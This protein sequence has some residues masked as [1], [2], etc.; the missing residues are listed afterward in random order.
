L[1]IEAGDEGAVL[2]PSPPEDVDAAHPYLTV[3][4]PLST[5]S[6]RWGG[7]D[8]AAA[9]TDEAVVFFFDG[10]DED[11]SAAGGLFFFFLGLDGARA[12][13]ADSV[14]P[15]VGGAFRFLAA[16]GFFFVFGCCMSSGD[17]A[18]APSP[19]PSAEGRASPPSPE[20]GSS[21]SEEGGVPE[22][23]MGSVVRVGYRSEG[24]RRDD[25]A[26][27]K[28]ERYSVHHIGYLFSTG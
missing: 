18:V 25:G 23:F 24:R 11:S 8:G 15:A 6:V 12:G 9:A 10:T 26:W 13:D 3:S 16:A 7:T 5:T 1:G 19:S 20:D 14:P 28:G 22:S 27:Q 4:P 17:V 2:E 21:G